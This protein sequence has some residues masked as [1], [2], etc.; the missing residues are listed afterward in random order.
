[1]IFFLHFS[2]EYAKSLGRYEIIV[3]SKVSESG[4]FLSHSLHHHVHRRD[5]THKL[6]YQVS[7]DGMDLHLAL[8]PN[9]RM[10]APSLVV[11]RRT[12]HF[13]NLSDS[14]IRKFTDNRCHF[15]GSIK[16]HQDSKVAIAT[17]NGLVSKFY[18]YRYLV[19]LWKL[20]LKILQC[21]A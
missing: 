8:E 2:A 11:E 3:P 1:M 19:L 14:K 10:F 4:Q 7:V 18:S 17:C 13:G 21:L 6:H 20:N 5:V 9:H 12:A 15:T 16:G